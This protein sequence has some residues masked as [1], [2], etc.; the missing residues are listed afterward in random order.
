MFAGSA[1]NV[2]ALRLAYEECAFFLSLLCT[3]CAQDSGV[4]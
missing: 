1:K 2:G 3:N 4:Q